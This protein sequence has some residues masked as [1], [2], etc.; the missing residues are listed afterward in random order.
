MFKVGIGQDS[1]K[2]QKH[3]KSKKPLIL[4]GVI[5][6]KNIEV[7]A[8]SDGDILIHSLCNAINTALGLGSFDIY[9][10]PLC[11]SGVTDSKEYLL[12][13]S[14]KIKQAGYLISNI[15]IMIEAG[16]PRLETYRKKIVASLSAILHL[17]KNSIGIAS[18]SGDGLTSFAKG[19]GIQCFSIVSLM[20]K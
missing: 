9:A 6:D 11:R 12:I 18:T 14:N 17:D 4:G 5:I 19:K 16:Y 2:I 1:H 10:G 3:T 13:A 20:T 8:D 7:K 15:S